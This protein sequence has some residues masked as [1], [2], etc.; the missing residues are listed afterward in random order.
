MPSDQKFSP[1]LR[2]FWDFDVFQTGKRRQGTQCFKDAQPAVGGYLIESQEDGFHVSFDVIH[3]N[4]LLP[5]KMC[6]IY[7]LAEKA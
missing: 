6:C 2:F 3:I 7:I 5:A 1:K 4:H